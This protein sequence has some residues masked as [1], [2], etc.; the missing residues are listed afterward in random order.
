[1]KWH[2]LIQASLFEE[3]SNVCAVVLGMCQLVM[4]QCCGT[5]NLVLVAPSCDRCATC[6]DRAHR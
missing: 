3:R 1:M 5:K 6:C 4:Q 2:L